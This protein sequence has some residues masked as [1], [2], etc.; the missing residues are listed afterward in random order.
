VIRLLDALS[1]SRAAV[2][3]FSWGAS[4]AVR[5]AAGAPQRV[6]A[7]V[8]LEG[9]YFEPSDEPDYRARR[10]EEV[11]ADFRR[12]QAAFRFPDLATYL[13][14]VTN[15][16]TARAAQA[17]RYRAAVEIVDGDVVP[18]SSADA[19][20]AARFG[21]ESEPTDGVLARLAATRVPTLVA[22]SA[23]IVASEPA[24]AR[25]L[26]RF[27]ERVGHADVELIDG[28]GHDVLAEA[29]AR[30]TQLV[31]EWLTDHRSSSGDA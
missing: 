5:V 1:I 30:T 21:L 9:G 3:G 13:G 14:A 23:E 16:R 17:E 28:A 15:E 20:A 31:G 2:G 24:A 26:Q 7:L 18:R 22:A 27:R 8:L 4:V 12:Q 6:A 10:L 11:E 29:P 19:A 25:A